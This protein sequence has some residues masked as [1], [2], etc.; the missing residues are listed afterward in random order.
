MLRL[1]L[2]Q[3]DRGQARG[4]LLNYSYAVEW[5]LLAA[6]TAD[7]QLVHEVQ[8]VQDAGARRV[9]QQSEHP[10]QPARL[11]QAQHPAP[12]L[13]HAVRVDRMQMSITHACVPTP[14]EAAVMQAPVG[15]PLRS[16]GPHRTRVRSGSRRVMLIA[17]GGVPP[18][19]GNHDR[20]PCRAV[21]Q[22]N[23]ALRPSPR[24]CAVAPRALLVEPL[25]NRTAAIT[26]AEDGVETMA[27]R[28][29]RPFTPV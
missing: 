27:S 25:R 5:V 13:C 28:A 18:Y 29:F 20:P 4:G 6:L 22:A 12:R 21:Q 14:S 3:W 23:V 26:G 9:G 10:G 15:S 19:V 16:A 17:D 1:A 24:C 11:V 2:W 8:R 7:A